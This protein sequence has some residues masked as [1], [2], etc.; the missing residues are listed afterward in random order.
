MT[1]TTIPLMAAYFII[2]QASTPYDLDTLGCTAL[3]HVKQG[4]QFSG[5]IHHAKGFICSDCHGGDIESYEQNEGHSKEK[6]FIGRPK[7]TDVPQVCGKCHKPELADYLAGIHAETISAGGAVCIDCH[8]NH[9]VRGPED[10][11]STVFRTHIPATCG[12]CHPGPMENFE[13]SAHAAA[14]E[15][16]SA[17]V[18]Q[19]EKMKA[20]YNCHGNHKIAKAAPALFDETCTKCHPAG[21]FEAQVGGNMKMALAQVRERAEKIKAGFKTLE[22]FGLSTER[23]RS[24]L[25]Q[26]KSMEHQALF[27]S[28]T[29]NEASFQAVLVPAATL[30]ENAEGVLNEFEESRRSQWTALVFTWIVL[31]LFILLLFIKLKRVQADSSGKGGFH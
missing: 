5:S 29:V 8:T 20:C 30:L 7:R 27:A 22:E 23:W 14:T 31:G 1:F 25:E 26:L 21:S 6:G 12:K 4:R 3:C 19:T 24:E 9:A 28:H 16:A 15:D 2:A 17:T 13:Q 18:T 10:A 11:S